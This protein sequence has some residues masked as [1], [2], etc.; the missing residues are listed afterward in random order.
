[1]PTARARLV[2]VLQ[3]ELPFER[4]ARAERAE[5]VFEALDELKAR[6]VALAGDE[7]LCSS[8]VRFTERTL[9]STP[10]ELK[11]LKIAHVLRS[12]TREIPYERIREGGSTVKIAFCATAEFAVRERAFFATLPATVKRN[13]WIERVL[14]AAI[15][16]YERERGLDEAAAE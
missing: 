7:L 16:A 6:V 3:T 15:D 9:P 2:E 12:G 4:A 13:A 1:M 14:E 8:L 10:V 5:R 11:K